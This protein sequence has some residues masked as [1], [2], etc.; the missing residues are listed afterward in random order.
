MK[1]LEN[2][3]FPVFMIKS[4]VNT[5]YKFEDCLCLLSQLRTNG[6]GRYKIIIHSSAIY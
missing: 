1:V 5:F 6:F 3:Y 4:G 2:G